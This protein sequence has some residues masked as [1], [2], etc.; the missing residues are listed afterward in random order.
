[1]Y[2]LSDL[3]M[4][5]CRMAV[6]AKKDF[7]DDTERPLKVATKFTH[8]LSGSHS[9]QSYPILLSNAYTFSPNLPLG[10]AIFNIRLQKLGKRA[11]AIGFAVNLEAAPAVIAPPVDIALLYGD[12]A[13]YL[14][15]YLTLALGSYG[16]GRHNAVYKSAVRY[17]EHITGLCDLLD[18]RNLGD[19]V[20][21][22][23]SVVNHLD[24]YNGIIYNGF[25]RDYPKAVI[26]G[27]QY[28]KLPEKLGKRAQAIGF[29]VNLEAAPAVIHI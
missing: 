3:K 25:I 26:V 14:V 21:L 9:L 6:A 12:L 4:G 22:D 18:K 7:I 10:N 13:C 5:K 29:A 15:V 20:R 16:Q 27:G 23:F 17:V 19:K 11:Q 2:E 8:R 28:D 24:Y 1:M